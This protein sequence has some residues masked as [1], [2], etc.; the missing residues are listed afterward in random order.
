MSRCYAGFGPLRVRTRIPSTRQL[1]ELVSLR[2]FC[3]SVNDHN[4]SRLLPLFSWRS[5]AVST[6]YFL[7]AAINLRPP[8]VTVSTH[9]PASNIVASQSSAMPNTRI[10]LCTQSV[11][12]FSFPTRSL[13][14]ATSRFP[15]MIC[16]GNR[17][18]L[19]RMSAPVHKS[20]LVR[21]VVSML[22]HPVISRAWLCEYIPWSDLLCCAPM[23]RSKTRRCTVRS[24]R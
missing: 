23:M 11:H 3:A 4:F 1:G 20:V 16:F 9:T 14:N 5:L 19:I 10:S 2:T 18:P 8:S 15:N 21:N 12:S 22:S 6:S 17:P 7:H 13:R 24:L